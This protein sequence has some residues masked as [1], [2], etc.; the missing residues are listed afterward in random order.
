MGAAG[1][2]VMDNRIHLWRFCGFVPVEDN[3]G[4][5]LSLKS[6]THSSS[7]LWGNSGN[8]QQRSEH[9]GKKLWGR[10]DVRSTFDLDRGD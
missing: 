7:A 6:V 3:E 1:G 2:A 9:I 5:I 8:D 4:L 10:G